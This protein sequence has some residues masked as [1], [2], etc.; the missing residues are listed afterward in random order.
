MVGLMHKQCFS[1]GLFLQLKGRQ[2]RRQ[3]LLNGY[4]VIFHIYES[5]FIG[6]ST[7]LQRREGG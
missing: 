4:D 2:K 6:L 1:F 3:R 7:T 5:I